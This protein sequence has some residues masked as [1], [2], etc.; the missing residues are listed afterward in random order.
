M[1]VAIHIFC[2]ARA[3]FGV[4]CCLFLF[5]CF[6]AALQAIHLSRDSRQI[7]ARQ[8]EYYIGLVESIHALITAICCILSYTSSSRCCTFR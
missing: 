4:D 8:V 6:Q 7:F 1:I 3:P 2:V 5:R